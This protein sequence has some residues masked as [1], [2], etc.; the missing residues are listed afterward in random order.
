MRVADRIRTQSVAPNTVAIW[1]LG[2]NS[3]V[4]KGTGVS[5]MIDPFFS[6]PGDPARYVRDEAPIRADEL[7]PDAVLCT[8]NHSDHTDPPFLVALAQASPET[9]FFGPPESARA[10]VEAGIASERVRALSPGEALEVG[11]ATVGVVLSKT[12]EVSDVGHFGY[13]VNIGGI[14]VYDTGDIMRGVTRVA[15]L[16]DPLRGAA[17]HIALITTSP[18]EDEF[19]DF[20]EA[21][22]LAIAV[23]ARVAVPAHYDCFAKRTFDPAGFAEAVG[24]QAANL[25]AEIIPYCGCF[26]FALEETR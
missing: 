17:P 8:H 12:A 15:G 20:E 26:V 9:R 18:T 25:R 16:M 22:Q 14:K 7:Q 4:I 2:Q 24:A 6:R 1:W 23:G 3:Y 11:G 19:P 5:I 10:M 13:I 21:A